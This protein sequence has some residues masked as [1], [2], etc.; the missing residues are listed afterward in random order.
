MEYRRFSVTLKH[1]V[2]QAGKTALHRHA[3]HHHGVGGIL[4]MD[5]IL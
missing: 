2:V 1:P 3:E 5:F 4:G